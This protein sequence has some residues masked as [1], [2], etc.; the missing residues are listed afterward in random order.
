MAKKAKKKRTSGTPSKVDVENINLGIEH[1]RAYLKRGNV[2]FWEKEQHDGRRCF[3]GMYKSD[4]GIV[5]NLFWVIGVESDGVK[6]LCNIPLRVPKSR[7]V[8][9]VRFVS[10]VNEATT[11]RGTF[12]II[13]ESG[14]VFLWCD[15]P[16]V[17]IEGAPD[18]AMDDFAISMLDTAAIYADSLLE[19]IM[20]ASLPNPRETEKSNTHEKGKAKKNGRLGKVKRMRKSDAKPSKLTSDY[21]LDGLGLKSD[22]PHYVKAEA[23]PA[24]YM[25]LNGQPRVSA[26]FCLRWAKWEAF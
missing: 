15:L 1:F 20:D 2:G 19:V 5:S 7:R 10:N 14:E 9:V 25:A 11:A 24:P 16:I 3:Y 12:T 17:A 8:T 22:V 13:A 18:N 21:S 23:G 6:L 4:D 26:T